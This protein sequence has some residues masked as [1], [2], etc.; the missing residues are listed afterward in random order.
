MESRGSIGIIEDN[1]ELQWLYKMVLESE[2]YTI[3]Y[4]ARNS[5]MAVEEHIRCSHKPKLLIIDNRLYNSTGIEAA[6][7]IQKVD[8]NAKI[9]FAT[10]DKSLEE[11]MDGLN[12]VEVLY[13]PFTMRKLTMTVNNAICQQ[14]NSN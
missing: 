12:T 13:K 6:K 5:D 8:P 9:I 4:T 2:G 1:L 14:N 7:S 11:R 10:V 3:A